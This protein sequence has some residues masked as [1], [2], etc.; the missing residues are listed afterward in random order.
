LY[1]SGIVKRNHDV[2]R[3]K[4]FR[5]VQFG[6]VAGQAFSIGA[7]GAVV[8]GII[9]GIICHFVCPPGMSVC[10]WQAVSINLLDVA[11][12]IGFL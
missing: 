6:A 9:G 12:S 5:W 3:G 10:L 1:Y 8:G 11:F 4:T 7:G 2:D